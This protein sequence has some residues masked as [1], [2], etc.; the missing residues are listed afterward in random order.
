MRSKAHWLKSE[1]GYFGLIDKDF[2]VRYRVFL[3]CYILH[4]DRKG[5]MTTLLE[6]SRSRDELYLTLKS[7]V[8][9]LVRVAMKSGLPK[10]P[11]V[12]RKYIASPSIIL[13]ST[14]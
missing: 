7:M 12:K 4:P 11:Y 5:T 9:T 8:A 3:L 10:I 14:R 6:L 1:M 13:A 2:A